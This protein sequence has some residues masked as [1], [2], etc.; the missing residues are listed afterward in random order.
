MRLYRRTNVPAAPIANDV[1]SKEGRRPRDERIARAL[2]AMQSDP[3]RRW[4]VAALA[5]VA[6]LSRAAFARRFAV[7]VGQSPLRHLAA[8]RIGWAAELLV[9]TDDGLAEIAARVGYG[10]EFALSRAFH[11]VVGI[12]PGAFRRAASGG[13]AFAPRCIAA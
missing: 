8:L 2:E 11:R 10:N 6:G 3:T 7:E 1:A 9:A 12:A 4:T 13:A 5:K